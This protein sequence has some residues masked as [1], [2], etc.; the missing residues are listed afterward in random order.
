MVD[1]QKTRLYE[2]KVECTGSAQWQ[3]FT[4]VFHPTKYN[5]N[6]TEFKIMLYAYWP[7]GVAWFDNVKLEAVDEPAAPADS[8]AAPAN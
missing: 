4:G 5:P 1:G 2:G 7:D 6:V 8:A 3:H